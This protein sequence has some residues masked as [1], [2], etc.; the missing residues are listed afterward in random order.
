MMTLAGGFAFRLLILVPVLRGAHGLE[1][2]ERATGL[3]ASTHH[4]IRLSGWA[5]ALLALTTLAALV[6]QTS[7]VT[8][9]D[10]AEALSPARL[11]EVL[12]RTG[13][14]GLWL[15]QAATVTV[16]A[17]VLFLPAKRICD[18]T[19]ERHLTNAA[20]HGLLWTGVIVTALMM[21]APSLTGHA[22]A[23]AA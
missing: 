11:Y 21:L 18:T 15:L 12:T 23:A 14:G 17:F 19:D 4:F 2:D 7:A 6:L 20:N 1:A 13:Y 9:A 22:R 16:L 8:D 10:F 3:S 5:L